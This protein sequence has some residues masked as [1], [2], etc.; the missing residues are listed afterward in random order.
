MQKVLLSP[1][2]APV[3]TV[4]AVGLCIALSWILHP[5]NPTFFFGE[6]G[7]NEFMTYA[8]YGIGLIVALGYARDYLKTDR[9]ASY[10]ALLFLWLSALLR[11]AGI[12]HWLTD[13]DTTAIKLRFFTNPNNPL[14]EKIVAA[15]LVVVVLGTAVWLLCRY[16]P[17]LF[18]GFFALNPLAWTVATFGGV[19]IVSQF[20][21]RFPSNYFK[22]TGVRLDD[23]VIYWF[24]AVEES[25]EATLPLLFALGFIQYH[26][27]REQNRPKSL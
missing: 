2:F 21:D 19:G 23:T 22:A 6:D 20:A 1:L 3:A 16:M 17:G 4:L 5:G 18:R 24:K 14:S 15:V 13:H 9:Q 26:L 8:G 12:Q 10:F 11:E 27:L 25:G 7:E